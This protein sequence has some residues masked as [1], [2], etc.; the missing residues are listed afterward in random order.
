MEEINFTPGSSVADVVFVKAE[1]CMDYY[2]KTGNGIPIPGAGGKQ[3]II[4]VELGKDVDPMSGLVQKL[5]ESGCT[6]CLRAIGIDED[7]TPVALTTLAVG[8]GS[9]ARRVEHISITTNRAN[10]VS[11]FYRV[12]LWQSADNVSRCAR[13]I[14]ASVE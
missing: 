12:T 1:D 4:W 11:L 14:S 8:K 3:Q 9:R 6:R 5:L 7:W 2:N 13:Q 10:G